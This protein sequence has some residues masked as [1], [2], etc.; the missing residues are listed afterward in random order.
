MQYSMYAHL[1]A[2]SDGWLCWFGAGLGTLC[3]STPSVLAWPVLVLVGGGMFPDPD[4]PDDP[5]VA[6]V[7]VSPSAAPELGFSCVE[8]VGAELG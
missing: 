4:T 1:S 8:G 2:V 7:D 5:D 6:D 3:V